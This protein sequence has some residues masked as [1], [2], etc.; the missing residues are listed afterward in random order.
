MLQSLENHHH[1]R[2]TAHWQRK[3]GGAGELITEPEQ[4][5]SD[6]DTE[7]SYT[8]QSKARTGTAEGGTKA[9]P[10]SLNI[11]GQKMQ[12]IQWQMENLLLQK[13]DMQNLSLLKKAKCALKWAKLL[14]SKVWKSVVCFAKITN[15]NSRMSEC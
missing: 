11:Y 7:E 4:V 13:L 12:N 5:C 8:Q 14:I 15:D 1:S 6:Q 10:Y 3:A 2:S 9:D